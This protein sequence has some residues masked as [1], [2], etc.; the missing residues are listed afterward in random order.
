MALIL[1]SRGHTIAFA[2][3]EPGSDAMSLDLRQVRGKGHLLHYYFGRGGRMVRVALSEFLLDGSLQTS[4]LDS[5][6]TWTV[7]LA[8]P[9]RRL[10]ASS[11]AATGERPGRRAG[12]SLSGSPA[13]SPLD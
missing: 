1:D 4:W 12:S 13:D 8:D 10:H 3:L 7:R 6:R 2:E 11:P 9:R 5:E